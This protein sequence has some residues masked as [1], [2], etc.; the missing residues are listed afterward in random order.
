MLLYNV[1]KHMHSQEQ[2]LHKKKSSKENRLES[3]RD[4]LK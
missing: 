1:L 2:I 3:V 4:L